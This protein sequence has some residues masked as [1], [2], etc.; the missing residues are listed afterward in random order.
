[1]VAGT[2]LVR[3]AG[4][5][6]TLADGGAPRFKKAKP[7]FQNFVAAGQ[8]VSDQLGSLLHGR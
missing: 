1:V 7:V 2:A 6:V 4:G 8:A 3:A 5:I